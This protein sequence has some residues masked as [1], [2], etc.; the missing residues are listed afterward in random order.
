MTNPMLEQKLMQ[1]VL[2]EPITGLA[3]VCPFF[4]LATVDCKI[5]CQEKICFRRNDSYL[6]NCKSCLK[7][8]E[9]HKRLTE[10]NE[11]RKSL[12]PFHPN[13][14]KLIDSMHLS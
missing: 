14:D 7:K 12:Q 5:T 8:N 3:H 1:Y 2:H 4:P 6:N 9:Y 10:R 13:T 11:R